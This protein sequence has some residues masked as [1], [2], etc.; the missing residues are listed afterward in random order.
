MK[1]KKE[2]KLEHK[3]RRKLKMGRNGDVK[4]ARLLA[5]FTTQ[6]ECDDG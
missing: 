2:W 5:K 4:T 3:T 1:R 6:P